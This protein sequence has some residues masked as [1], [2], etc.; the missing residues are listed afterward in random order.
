MRTAVLV[1]VLLLTTGCGPLRPL[2]DTRT[3]PY[4][5]GEDVVRAELVERHNG[6][7]DRL[8]ATAAYY[9][10]E[11]S[12]SHVKARIM[13]V[14]VGVGASGSGATIAVLAQPELPDD[15]RPGVASFGVSMAVFSGLMAI[16][17]WAHQYGLKEIGY[18]RQADRTWSLYRDIQVEGGA[19]VVL[20]PD[21]PVADLAACVSR[22]ESALVEVRRLPED[23]PC[24]PPL[25]GDLARVLTRA[26][27]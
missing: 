7:A 17:P 19:G 14:L 23:S 26:R 5:D 11:V 22:L 15:A 1:G 10:R 4:A 24:R 21:R 6:L 9:D 2:L 12:K 18:S 27:R 20:D 25:D 13:S 3:N 16:L 8:Q